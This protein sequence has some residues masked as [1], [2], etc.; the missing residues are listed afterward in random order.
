MHVVAV[1]FWGAFFGTV[2]L[3]LVGA[4]A[5]FARSRHRVALSAALTSI[6][7]ALFAVSYLGGLRVGDTALEARLMAHVGL[8][9]AT[10]L[11]LMLLTEL[12]LLRG[13][14]LGRRVRWRMAALA[15]LTL[16]VGWLVSAREALALSSFVA[17][18]IGLVGLV[19]A[20]RS[21]RRGNRLAWLTVVGVVFM[22]MAIA[23]LTWIA[24]DRQGVPW[25]V[26]PASALAGII[27]V[28][29]VQ[30]MLWR[31]YSY[32]IELREVLAQ[33]PRYDPVT[34]MQSDAA[35]GAMVGLAFVHQQQHPARPLALIAI[36]IGNLS[37]LETLHG[38]AAL[39]HAL[40]VCAGRLRRCVPADIEMA[41]HFDDGF[42][43]VARDSGDWQRMAQLSR[44]VAVRLSQP[45]VLSTSAVA[46]DLEAQQAVW[47]PDVGV[48]VLEVVSYAN[49]SIAVSRV[50][51][52]SR[53]ARGYASRV[54]CYDEAEGSV[55]ELPLTDAS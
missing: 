55:R 51:E 45:V 49:P 12:G 38:R 10:L 21:A 30:G 9:S 8:I 14:N 1:G 37:A 22:L 47:T 6:L 48:G 42:L 15:A 46:R 13:L 40:F 11:G 28:T 18:C 16:G 25:L 50:G 53:L 31:R 20:V 44:L 29:S 24:L 39:N 3:M 35:A 17:F 32:L 54:A 41:R 4:L 26:H 27:Y 34:R 33:G 52:M 19:T 23:G 7:S 36:S 5:A 43:L 2:A